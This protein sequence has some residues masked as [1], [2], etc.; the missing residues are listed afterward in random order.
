MLKIIALLMLSLIG[1]GDDPDD[2][3]TGDDLAIE[4]AG[5]YQCV[6][7]DTGLSSNTTDIVN[8]SS[9][10]N[11]NVTL[12]WSGQ[13]TPISEQ[14]GISGD[15]IFWN[16]NFSSDFITFNTSSNENILSFRVG[17][18]SGSGCSKR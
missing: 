9:S 15:R 2:I 11:S 3:L 7:L 4:L 17:K 14:V 1:C 6:S 8:V 12:S 5:S 18:T 16:D 13:N 10:S